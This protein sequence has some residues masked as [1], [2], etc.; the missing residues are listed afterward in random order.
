MLI[1]QI[2]HISH[3]IIYAGETKI[4]AHQIR[5]LPKN[6]IPGQGFGYKKKSLN[7]KDCLFLANRVN[8]SK[9]VI[10]SIEK[11]GRVNRFI[12]TLGLDK[13]LFE[14]G[15]LWDEGPFIISVL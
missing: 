8:S 6:I 2:G 13:N 3:I 1:K 7:K 12:T 14:T 9:K 15:N 11:S 4:D 10:A 5:Q